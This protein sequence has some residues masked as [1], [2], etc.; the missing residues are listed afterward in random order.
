MQVLLT[1]RGQIALRYNGEDEMYIRKFNNGWSTWRRVWHSGNNTTS[2]N[3]SG[4][5]RLASGL[6][7]QCGRASAVSQSTISF[8]LAFPNECFQV[9]VTPY[10]NYDPTFVY[11][12]T[13]NGFEVRRNNS[14]N[15]FVNYIAVGR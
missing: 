7:I 12:V 11:A 9:V 2:L 6:I 3:N 5:Q 8:P 15:V 10:Q 13:R 14:N 1:N 4:Y